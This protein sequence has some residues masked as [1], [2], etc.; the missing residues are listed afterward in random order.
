MR[1]FLSLFFG[2]IALISSMI[3]LFKV[4]K[5]L[6]I[7]SLAEK[8]WGIGRQITVHDNIFSGQFGMQR[9]KQAPPEK[10]MRKSPPGEYICKHDINIYMIEYQENI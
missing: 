7:L 9:C 4:C 8:Y 3:R 1:P 5:I 10:K 2:Y 6:Q